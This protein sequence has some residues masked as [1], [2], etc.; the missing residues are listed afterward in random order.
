M[1]YAALAFDQLVCSC[2]TLRIT[3]TLPVSMLM[4]LTVVIWLQDGPR[5]GGARLYNYHL[6]PILQYSPARYCDMIISYD[7]IPKYQHLTLLLHNYVQLD[8]QH[9]TVTSAS[10]AISLP[11]GGSS[12]PPSA[13][14]A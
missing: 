12:L 9:V 7:L 11:V 2:I 5:I 4:L 14:S 10:C 3:L 6:M 13:Y 8:K 1:F